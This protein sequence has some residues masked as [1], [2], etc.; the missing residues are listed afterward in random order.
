[1]VNIRQ[2]SDVFKFSLK[3]G[4]VLIKVNGVTEDSRPFYGEYRY[5]IK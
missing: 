4:T 1:M 2:T 5:E 3:K